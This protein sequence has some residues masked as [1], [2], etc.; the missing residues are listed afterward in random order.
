MVNEND[1]QYTNDIQSNQEDN[2]S[3]NS[4]RRDFIKS[5]TQY[6]I[7]GLSGYF[8]INDI[9]TCSTDDFI[10]N[11]NSYYKKR[12]NKIPTDNIHIS[13][14]NQT[15]RDSREVCDTTCKTLCEETCGACN[16]PGCTT[17]KDCDNP[18]I[19]DNEHLQRIGKQDQGRIIMVNA[20]KT[21]TDANGKLSFTSPYSARF[22]EIGRND[23]ID[24]LDQS[25]DT[26]KKK[27][28]W[29]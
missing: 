15:N 20:W 26:L 19:N 25:S 4:N 22:R 29:L 13:S 8:L 9:T 28:G 6:G 11:Y 24:T 16:C 5:I 21:T 2:S 14:E 23:F 18:L 12:C 3:S 17:P 10:S 27:K 1:N 7:L